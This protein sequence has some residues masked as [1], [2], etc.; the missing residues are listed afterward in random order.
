MRK[1]ILALAT[2][3]FYSNLLAQAPQLM[4]YQAV[5]RNGSNQ[6]LSNAPVGMR[7]SVLQGSANG[8]AV[9]SETHSVTTNAQGLAALSIGGGTPQSGTFAGIDWANGPFF[10]KAETDPAGGTNYSITATSQLLLMSD[11][12]IADVPARWQWWLEC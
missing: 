8:N 9:Y 3:L 4:S 6:L 11:Y 7:I 12:G 10:L 1:T 2:V 5:V